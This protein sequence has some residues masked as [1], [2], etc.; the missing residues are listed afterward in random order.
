MGRKT[1]W[2]KFLSNPP[3]RN[4]FKNIVLMKKINK[5]SEY[6]LSQHKKCY[7]FKN[8]EDPFTLKNEN[9]AYEVQFDF[10]KNAKSFQFV[11]F[12]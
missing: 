3:L 1:Y 9:E 5:V 2:G 10:Q 4:L 12:S 7:N 11:M 8:L 6:I